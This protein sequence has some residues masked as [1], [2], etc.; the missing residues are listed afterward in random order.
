M[1]QNVLLLWCPEYCLSP[2]TG[3]DACLTVFISAMWTMFVK[4][5]R[6]DKR[7]EGKIEI[8]VHMCPWL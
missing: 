3:L 4:G 5:S 6:V 1:T 2:P 7:M 8:S